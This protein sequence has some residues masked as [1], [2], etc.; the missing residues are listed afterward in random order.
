MDVN[1]PNI[2]RDEYPS[3][4]HGSKDHR[5]V[6][7]VVTGKV[8]NKKKSFCKQMKENILGEDIKEVSSYVF[9]DTLIPALKSTIVDMLT[10]GIEMFFYGRRTSKSSRD[11]RTSFV[12]Y[13]SMYDKSPSRKETSSSRNTGSFDD[14]V[15]E[16]YTDADTVLGHLV[17]LVEEYDMVTV[18]DLY[19]LVG[20]PGNF[21]DN[22]YG[23]MNLSSAKVIRVR[24]GYVID[25]P[26][27]ILID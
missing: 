18:A 3:N 12:S 22:K 17:D 2:N 6:E 20:K 9:W 26:R 7:K 4:A 15:F 8:V 11:K 25:L 24:N 14:L 23:W 27:P 21:T 5:K 10:G 16:T 19:D 13:N 1:R